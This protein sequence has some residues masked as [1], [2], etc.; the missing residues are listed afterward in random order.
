MRLAGG[1]AVGAVVPGSLIGSWLC[2]PHLRKV[3]ANNIK[4]QSFGLITNV[5]RLACP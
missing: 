5:Q 3:S 4:L 1:L 2:A